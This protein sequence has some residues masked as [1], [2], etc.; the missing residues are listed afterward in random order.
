MAKAASSHT[1]SAEKDKG[2]SR[3][4]A[5]VKRQR[6]KSKRKSSILFD[7]LKSDES[8]NVENGSSLENQTASSKRRKS[9]YFTES[10]TNNTQRSKDLR[11]TDLQMM[12]DEDPSNDIANFVSDSEDT[13][14]DFDNNLNTS[15]ITIDDGSQ[16]PS[17][18]ESCFSLAEHQL[19]SSGI[20]VAC[21]RSRERSKL[22][23][24]KLFEALKEDDDD[25]KL[26]DTELRVCEE[27]QVDAS[28]VPYYA[29]KNL[30]FDSRV[31]C[32]ASIK[33]DRL[34]KN[35]SKEKSVNGSERMEGITYA[36]YRE[37]TPNK[38]KMG[39]VIN[40]ATSAKN[41][42]TRGKDIL[43]Q[44]DSSSLGV[45]EED[46]STQ[47][48][49]FSGHSCSDCLGVQEDASIDN[50]D[51]SSR[52]YSA[53]NQEICTFS[54]V[55][56]CPHKCNHSFKNSS[57]LQGMYL[58]FRIPSLSFVM[59]GLNKMTRVMLYLAAVMCGLFIQVFCKQL[60]D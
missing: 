22:H 47:T 37:N 41:K 44:T 18:N 48:D 19:S 40:L 49:A 20:R 43:T 39:N 17:A 25:G 33:L 28:V 32:S 59:A 12:G 45:R 2:S 52:Q 26:S 35:I 54:Q 23:C 51:T 7:V 1:N 8:E 15:V 50:R 24:S 14:L 11:K 56:T 57:D 58:E 4:E 60:D 34:C 46:A 30:E 42:G 16:S 29:D 6:E 21:E 38:T 36:G 5:K 55:N 53:N 9:W 31:H 10:S 3:L 13:C 27:Q